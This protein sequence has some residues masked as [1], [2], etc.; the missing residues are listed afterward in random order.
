MY[1]SIVHS[2]YTDPAR[3]HEVD[4]TIIG[5]RSAW[6]DLDHDVGVD[7]T[8]HTDY[9]FWVWKVNKI[10]R[11]DFCDHYTIINEKILMLST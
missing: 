6:K 3:R 7:H 9:L 4:D 10:A 5:N 2:D 11:V 8:D 1:Y